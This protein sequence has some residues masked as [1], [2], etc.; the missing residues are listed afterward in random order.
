MRRLPVETDP[1]RKPMTG[2]IGSDDI[3]VL[4][5]LVDIVKPVFGEPAHAVDKHDRWTFPLVENAG[6][7]ALR[8]DHFCAHRRPLS[9]ARFAPVRAVTTL[10]KLGTAFATFG[11]AI[12]ARACGLR[13]G[14]VKAQ[15]K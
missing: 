9:H 15:P 6:P 11:V 14:S 1:L 2:E 10:G 4:C 8:I 7:N 13:R 5:Q 12:R 3:M